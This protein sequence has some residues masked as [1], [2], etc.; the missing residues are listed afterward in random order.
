MTHDYD[1]VVDALKNCLD[2]P[3]CRDCP[4]EECEEEH[5]TVM[6]PRRLGLDALRILRTGV[7]TD[8]IKCTECAYWGV[9]G[10]ERGFCEMH[11]FYTSENDFCSQAKIRGNRS[12]NQTGVL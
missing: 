1:T 8:V 2:L 11:F 6:I 9:N 12:E 4:W 3:Q 7:R 5:E 10:D